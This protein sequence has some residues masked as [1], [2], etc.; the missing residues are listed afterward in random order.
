MSVRRIVRRAGV[1]TVICAAIFGGSTFSQ[2]SEMVPQSESE[3]GEIYCGAQ[4]LVGWPQGTGKYTVIIQ[5]PG[6]VT[7]WESPWRFTMKTYTATVN[8]SGRWWVSAGD[9]DYPQTYAFCGNKR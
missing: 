9:L 2:A 3:G 5:A 8:K 7:Q 6:A 4:G 1:V